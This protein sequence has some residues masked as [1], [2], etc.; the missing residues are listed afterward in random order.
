MEL[1]PTLA[2]SRARDLQAERR[3]LDARDVR[4][5]RVGVELSL[6]AFASQ[7]LRGIGWGRFVEYST[8]HSEFPGCRRTTST[9]AS[10]PSSAASAWRCSLLA[11]FAI[12]SAFWRR[13]LDAHGIA[14]LGMLAT[15]A[16]GLVFVNALTV[17]AIA[18]PLGIAAAIACARAEPRALAEPAPEGARRCRGGRTRK[19]SPGG[20]ARN[21]R[22][23]AVGSALGR[24]RAC[25]AARSR[26]GLDPA[27]RSPARRGRR[28][29][30]SPA[31]RRRHRTAATRR[32]R[33]RARGLVVVAA[34]LRA[35]AA[36]RVARRGRRPARRGRPRA[37]A[38]RS[39]GRERRHA[40]GM[41][42]RLGALALATRLP[43]MLERHEIVPGGDSTQYALLA[44]TFFDQGS[45]SFVRPPGYPLFLALADL[46]P[47]RLEDVA[48]IAQLLLGAGLSAALVFFAW[49]LFGRLAA[50]VAGL[51]LALTAPFLSIESL[52]LADVLFGLLVTVAAALVAAA[53]LAEQRRMRWLVAA[54]VAIACATYVKPVGHALVLAPL[55]PLALATRSWRATLLGSGTVRRRR[56]AADRAV[57]GAQRRALRQLHDVRAVGRDARQPRLRARPPGAPHRPRRR[58]ARGALSR[59]HP[60]RR[61]STSVPAELVRGGD[62]L[63]EAEAKLR[64]VA[65]VA[66]RRDPGASRRE[67]CVRR[68]RASTTSRRA[69]ART[70][71]LRSSRTGRCPGRRGSRCEPR[72]RCSRC[73]ACSPLS[74][75]AG[76]LWL[77]SRSRR[78]RVAAGAAIGAWA[79]S[80]SR[81]PRC[82]AGSFATRRASRR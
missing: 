26:R 46:L 56:G 17:V 41:G 9:C 67:R 66:A 40:R 25:G 14:L 37:R 71:S 48:V 77:A 74:G 51:L 57:D 80:P 82:T 49:P 47:G 1:S 20:C 38:A 4:S 22:P 79:P 64:E 6:E 11:G 70:R 81:R 12:A 5:R 19:R 60:D 65:L 31:R 28:G 3:R 13:R 54:G 8:A 62:T 72:S 35:R 52:L 23:R 59:E 75:L 63:A 43:L 50:V 30:R 61:L 39:G 15:G 68:A 55:L 76:L 29:A 21:G 73:G 33:A 2:G 36:A 42:S 16:A 32:P 34:P 44:R 18:A 10:S 45:V 69:R 78:T 27:A 7:P 58:T 24:R 53:A